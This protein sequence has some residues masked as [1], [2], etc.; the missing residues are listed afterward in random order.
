MKTAL[1]AT[2]LL[3][4]TV[5][6]AYSYYFYAAAPTGPQPNSTIMENKLTVGDHQRTYLSYAPA[7]LPDNPAMVIVLHGSS[8]NGATMRK[9]TGY[10]FDRLADRYGFV[11]SYPDGYKGNWNDCRMDASFPAKKE[12]ID[13]IG[14]IKALIEH[15]SERYHI[16]RSKVFVFGYSNGGQMAMRLAMETP[17]LVGAIA[18][19]CANLPTA[20]SC[21]CP[22]DGATPPVMLIAGDQ[23]EVNPYEGGDVRLFGFMKRGM[24]ISAQAT[25]AYF[26]QRNGIAVSAAPIQWPRK[27]E[28]DETYITQQNW[29]SGDHPFVTLYTVHGGGHTVPQPDFEFPRFLGKT[30]RNLDAPAA[31]VYFFGL[32]PVLDDAR[33]GTHLTP[34]EDEKPADDF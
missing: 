19:V 8:I 32:S 17:R 31:A 34:L 24:A 20:E 27:D 12:N 7:Q 14:F 25:A 18:A 9:W 6:V 22:A 15:Y 2:L 13:D 10:G 21:S 29:I 11:V 30:S 28:N 5:S 1:W 33:P 23:D 26:A 4:I 16:D 3:M